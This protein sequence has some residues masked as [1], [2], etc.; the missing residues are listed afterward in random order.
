MLFGR[1]IREEPKRRPFGNARG[2]Q[3][4]SSSW[5]HMS[6]VEKFAMISLP[7]MMVFMF[8]T[9]LEYL[10][11]MWWMRLL[12]SIGIEAL[13]LVILYWVV[14]FFTGRNY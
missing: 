14:W 13:I 11:W 8:Y 5:S 6:I 2:G 10:E 1:K 4:Q 9:I 12:V 7:T 3:T